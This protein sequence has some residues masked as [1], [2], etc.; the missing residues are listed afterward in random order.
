VK[1]VRYSQLSKSATVLLALFTLLLLSVSSSGV[2]SSSPLQ[3]STAAFAQTPSSSSLA[4]E[5]I[6]ETATSVQDS[7]AGDNILGD[8]NEFGDEAAAI[9]QDN[10]AEQDAANVGL[11][12]EDATQ[13]QEQEQDA[14][15]TNLDLDVQEGVQRPPP[16]D[17]GQ[18]PECTLEITADKEIYQPEDVVAITITNTG[19][20]P[21][22]F[23]NSAL[24]LQIKNVDTGEVFPLVAAQVVTTLEPGESRTFEFTYE[25]LVSEIGTGLISA[26]VMS[27]CG[28]VKEVTFTL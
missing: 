25:E 9:G 28:G 3:T 13:E 6:D 16:G 10:E 17:G 24:G 27:E 18:E 26:T 5:I 8:S 22:E 15:N 20:E 19:D 1:S 21:I 7:S 14:A 2:L 11:Q 23:P 12:D 4:D